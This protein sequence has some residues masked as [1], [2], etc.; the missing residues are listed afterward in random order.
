MKKLFASILMILILGSVIF[1]T[2]RDSK[3]IKDIGIVLLPNQACRDFVVKSSNHIAGELKGYKKLHNKPH[4]T[5]IHIANLDKD[6]RREIKALFKEFYQEISDMHIDFPIIGVK[7]TG[8]SEIDGYK[9]LDLQF[10]TKEVLAKMHEKSVKKF[11]PLHKD[12]LERMYDDIEK[13]D[14]TQKAELDECGVT[15]GNYTPHMTMWYVDLPH[16][17]KTGKLH[18]IAE[19]LNE[20]A[21]SVQCYAE[22]VALVELGRNGNVTRIVK[23]HELKH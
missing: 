15:Y 23:Q 4:I 17:Q 22:S 21:K 16:E 1:K 7:A 18:N 20:Q 12:I 5:L 10:E 19:S 9:W 6:G 11:C 13:F 8:G 2:I 14:P 3:H